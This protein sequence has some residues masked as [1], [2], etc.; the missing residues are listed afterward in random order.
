MEIKKDVEYTKNIKCGDV[1][2]ESSVD[3]VLPDY[4]GDVRKILLSEVS[5]RPSGRFAGGDEVEFSGVVVYNVIF[6]D[7]NGGL[8]SVEFTS[9]YDYSVKCSG[10]N[11]NDSIA[12]TRVSNYSVRLI[13][14]RKINAKTSLVGNVRLSESCVLSVGGDGFD[15]DREPEINTGVA[16]LRVSKISSVLEREYAESVA[17]MD[18]AI[19][20]EV[21]IVHSSA[22]CSVDEISADD[23]GVSLKGHIRIQTVIR[24]GEEPAYRVEKTIP[25]DE[26]VDFEELDSKMH[27]IPQITVSSL[28]SNINADENGCEAVVSIILDICVIG[29]GNEKASL[30]LDG[31]HT[32][33]PTDNTY[34]VFDY[35]TLINVASVKGTH[36]AEIGR[37]ELECDGIREVVYLSSVPKI[38]QVQFD[39]EVAVVVGEI[40]YSGIVS[41]II[42]DNISY[43]GIKFSSPFATNVNVS[44]QNSDKTQI[45]AEIY[46][47]DTEATLDAEK[48]YASCTLETVVK[49]VENCERMILSSMTRCEGEKYESDSAKIT[50]YYP[51]K[52]ET[53]FSVAKRFHTSCLKVA[54]DNNIV[55]SVFAESNPSGSLSS[56]KKLIIY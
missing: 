16:D 54:N 9:D 10:E 51:D 39:G 15:S 43:S 26:R 55:E 47:R 45:E 24:N 27:L 42:N 52:N 31:Y 19:T 8:S 1:Y 22:E 3:F 34:D 7:S 38:E 50:V 44:C 2:T 36:N 6:L 17:R 49:V 13:G 56:V 20:D 46:A 28:K 14:P 30:V 11:Y 21:S 32:D 12:D 41:E 33:C 5:L 18:G 48:L 53:L 40:R 35:S 23:N 29:E 37:K 25:F 4:L